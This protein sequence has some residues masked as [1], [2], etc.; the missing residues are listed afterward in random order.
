MHQCDFASDQIWTN[1]H[2]N[3][4]TFW[5]SWRTCWSLWPMCSS[6]LQWKGLFRKLVSELEEAALVKF[7]TSLPRAIILIFAHHHCDQICKEMQ[8]DHLDSNHQTETLIIC[9]LTKIYKEVSKE[10]RC[11]WWPLKTLLLIDHHDNDH[12]GKLATELEGDVQGAQMA[13]KPF[14]LHA[15]IPAIR[16]LP[17]ILWWY[18]KT[19]NC[20]A[21]CAV[22]TVR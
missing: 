7:P 6:W 5:S 22:C 12:Q 16:W 21:Q 9:Y 2:C 15:Q 11:F 13:A 3:V 17:H 18:L 14:N 20:I 4:V 10:P 19:L 1:T 8:Y